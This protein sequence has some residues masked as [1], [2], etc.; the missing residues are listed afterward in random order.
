MKVETISTLTETLFLT[1]LQSENEKKARE[2]R[3]A[4]RRE[5]IDK[6]NIITKRVSPINT[7]KEDMLEPAFVDDIDV[8]MQV[9][10][11]GK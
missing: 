9:D 1:H 11:L 8:F 6:E 10:V 5:A 7:T 4:K 3:I 2:E